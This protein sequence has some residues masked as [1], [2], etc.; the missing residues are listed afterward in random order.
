MILGLFLRDEN[1][2]KL[3]KRERGE[4]LFNGVIS[5]LLKQT[6]VRSEERKG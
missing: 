1:R 3:K 4:D 5:Q 6:A 2:E